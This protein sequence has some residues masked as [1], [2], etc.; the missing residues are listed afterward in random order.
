MKEDNL[1][2]FVSCVIGIELFDLIKEQAEKEIDEI[3]K[4]LIDH[5]DRVGRGLANNAKSWC[6]D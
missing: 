4:S 1:Q 3:D 2:T 6:D 5:A